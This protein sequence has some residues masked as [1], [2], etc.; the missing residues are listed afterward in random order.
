VET[1]GNINLQT[2]TYKLELTNK[3]YN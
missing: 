3:N 2:K 1:A